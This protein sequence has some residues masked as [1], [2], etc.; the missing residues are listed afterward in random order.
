MYRSLPHMSPQPSRN[1]VPRNFPNIFSLFILLST[2]A[3]AAESVH[4]L[5]PLLKE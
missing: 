1:S 2:Q 3:L 4:S 5:L